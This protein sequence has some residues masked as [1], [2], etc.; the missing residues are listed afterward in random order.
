MANF[1]F[2]NIKRFNPNESSFEEIGLLIFILPISILT[3]GFLLTI[4]LAYFNYLNSWQLWVAS[5]LFSGLFFLSLRILSKDWKSTFVKYIKFSGLTAFGL[6]IIILVSLKS[7]Y[8]V[9]EFYRLFKNDYALELIANTKIV[10]KFDIDNYSPQGNDYHKLPPGERKVWLDGLNRYVSSKYN[11]EGKAEL[12]KKLKIYFQEK[13][14]LYKIEDV[15]I[16]AN[17]KEEGESIDLD[18][19]YNA[20]KKVLNYRKILINNANKHFTEKTIFTDYDELFL[21]YSGF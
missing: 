5:I 3:P 12:F 1:I 7:N 11:E 10:Q 20:R 9:R 19:F 15:L 4:I 8:F 21:F 6:L 17:R 16:N 2:K 13:D 18:S 14:N